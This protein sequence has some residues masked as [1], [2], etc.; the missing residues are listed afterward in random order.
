MH[1]Y[2][3]SHGTFVV[4]VNEDGTAWLERCDANPDNRIL[5]FND[6]EM[7]ELFS[8]LCQF[9]SEHLLSGGWQ[10]IV[11]QPDDNGTDWS[12]DDVPF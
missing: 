9:I 11:G 2:L 6:Q 12:E 3:S 7:V 8:L 5:V 10:W 4:E 1:K